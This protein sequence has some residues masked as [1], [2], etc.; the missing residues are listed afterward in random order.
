MSDRNPQIGDM[1]LQAPKMVQSNEFL[2]T[3]SFWG[4]ACVEYKVATRHVLCLMSVINE[5]L[6]WFTETC[7]GLAEDK[8][9]HV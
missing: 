8:H 2:Q 7:Y 4:N 1:R 9:A 5:P 6:G 3:S